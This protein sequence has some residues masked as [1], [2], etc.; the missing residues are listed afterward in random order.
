M[1]GNRMANN[2]HNK[3]VRRSLSLTLGTLGLGRSLWAATMSLGSI[4]LPMV[5]APR[6]ALSAARPA[7][8]LAVSRAR[9]R[10]GN[11]L[12][13]NMAPIGAN[14]A[15]TLSQSIFMTGS[16]GSLGNLLVVLAGFAGDGLS[17]LA[18]SS[19]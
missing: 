12:L 5:L 17:R 11:T 8:L 9:P 6:W 3:R 10:A 7:T 1:T 18:G 2:I 15:F 4:C 16:L 14:V 19:S 13:L